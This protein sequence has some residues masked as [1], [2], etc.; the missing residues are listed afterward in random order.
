MCV[1][2][3]CSTYINVSRDRVHHVQS[4][5]EGNLV[6][7]L[8]LLPLLPLLLMIMYCVIIRLDL[9]YLF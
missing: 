9:F 1:C 7:I 5:A 6:F 2:V 8:L 4:D 3:D